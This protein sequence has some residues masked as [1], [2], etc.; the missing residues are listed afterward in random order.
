MN[1]SDH[2]ADK[3]FKPTLDDPLCECGDAKHHHFGGTGANAL[4]GAEIGK[5]VPQGVCKAF[6]LD[7]ASLTAARESLS[8]R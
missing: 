2:A 1:E 5:P 3:N 4:R 6:K 7:G 8:T